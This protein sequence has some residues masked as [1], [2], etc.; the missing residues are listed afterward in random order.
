MFKIGHCRYFNCDISIRYMLDSIKYFDLIVLT[1]HLPRPNEYCDNSYEIVCE[2]IKTHPE[3]NIIHK[4]YPYIVYPASH[5]Y[6]KANYPNIDLKQT[7]SEYYNFGLDLIHEYIKEHNI[8]YNEVVYTKTDADII[9]LLGEEWYKKYENVLLNN[10]VARSPIIHYELNKDNVRYR[11]SVDLRLNRRD[12]IT[13]PG[14]HFKDL[15][16]TQTN[17]YE[18]MRFKNNNGINHVD[19][20]W[21]RIKT[22]TFIHI[23][24]KDHYV[25]KRGYNPNVWVEC[26]DYPKIIDIIRLEYNWEK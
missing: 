11:P 5:P 22:P 12:Y 17:L 4:V 19:Q 9:E 16:Y 14:K 3:M 6:F 8:N 13:I 20:S 2:Y 1:T 15:Y 23:A 26:K 21:N 18:V 25:D 10:P 7:T 24:K